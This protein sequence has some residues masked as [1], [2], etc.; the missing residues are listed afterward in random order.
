MDNPLVASVAVFA[1][2]RLL[3]ALDLPGAEAAIRALLHREKGV[4]PLYRALLTV[5]GA[6]CELAGG[7]PGD[8]TE[9]LDTPAVRQVM[10]AMRRY[11]S[12]LRTRYAE[13][14]LRRR[15]AAQAEEALQAFDKAAKDYPYPQEIENERE[16]IA[17]A[18]EA[19]V[20]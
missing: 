5:D 4:L 1:A 14:L 18:K 16:L 7:H 6:Y 15:D 3:N 10:N 17:I 20:L 8:L 11:P 13:A 9:A 12:V 19:A 2:N